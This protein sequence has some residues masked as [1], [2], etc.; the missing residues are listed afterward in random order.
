MPKNLKLVCVVRWCFFY[1]L[2]CSFIFVASFLS[3]VD[4]RL[5]AQDQDGVDSESGVNSTIT[6]AINIREALSDQYIRWIISMKEREGGG[7][8]FALS[9]GAMK[10]PEMFRTMISYIASVRT[11]HAGWHV[12]EYLMNLN[13][14]SKLSSDKELIDD[15]QLLGHSV[16]RAVAWKIKQR[17]KH[18]KPVDWLKTLLKQLAGEKASYL[19]NHIEEKPEPFRPESKEG[20]EI[21]LISIPSFFGSKTNKPRVLDLDEKKL[22]EWPGPKYPEPKT[23][24]IPDSKRIKLAEKIHQVSRK[25]NLLTFSKKLGLVIL[26]SRMWT[27]Q[28]RGLL[29]GKY[30]VKKELSKRAPYLGGPRFQ[31]MRR[32]IVEGQEDKLG[33]YQFYSASEEYG[34]VMAFSFV[35]RKNE[36]PKV[37]PLDNPKKMFDQIKKDKE[38]KLAYRNL[39]FQQNKLYTKVRQKAVK[40]VLSELHDKKDQINQKTARMLR[41]MGKLRIVHEAGRLVDWLSVEAPDMDVHPAREALADIGTLGT[42]RDRARLESSVTDMLLDAHK[43][44]E[45]K[46]TRERIKKTL[47]DIYGAGLAQHLIEN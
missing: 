16:S 14:P 6:R 17:K 46:A 29:Q 33:V 42:A 23:K 19:L 40:N 41:V 9:G 21:Y 11:P 25:Q 36:S 10:E 37:A 4:V 13:A 47:D 22:V 18:G 39:L 28:E 27:V 8:I 34:L 45:D 2:F 30:N 3:G 15:L 20:S 35:D 31:T 7:A 26:P 1:G 38:E 12:T 5:F 43:N 44:A 32:Y 24:H